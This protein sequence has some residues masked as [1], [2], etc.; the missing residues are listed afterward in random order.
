MGWY[1]RKAYTFGLFRIN[2]SKGGVGVSFGFPG[3]RIG[4]NRHGIYLHVGRGGVYYR[5]YIT[6]RERVEKDDP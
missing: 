5:R 6:R 3:F 1:I 2:L 4:I